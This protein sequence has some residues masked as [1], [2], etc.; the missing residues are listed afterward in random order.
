MIPVILQVGWVTLL[1]PNFL[2]WLDELVLIRPLWESKKG[3]PHHPKTKLWRL[4][5]LKGNH[6]AWMI[7]H[8]FFGTKIISKMWS[9]QTFQT[10]NL[11]KLPYFAWIFLKFLGIWDF[12]PK[13]LPKLGEIGRV[14]C[15]DS[16]WPNWLF[17]CVTTRHFIKLSA[18]PKVS[19]L[20]LVIWLSIFLPAKTT[21]K[22]LWTLFFGGGGGVWQSWKSQPTKVILRILGFRDDF[23]RR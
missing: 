12:L 14:W 8:I 23:N 9:T 20:P 16:I 19:C 2:E 13:R 6:R 15:R 18:I 5:G 11:A 4:W 1:Y 21:I 22:Q 7:L 10:M 17:L 3:T